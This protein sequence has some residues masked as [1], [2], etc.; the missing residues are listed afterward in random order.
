MAWWDDLWLNEAFATWMAFDIVHKWRPE[1][2]MW[3]DFG[4]SRDS[5]LEL[6]ALENTHPIYTKVRT[7]AEATENF[8]L[9]TYEKGASVI[10]MLERYLGEARFQR[11]VR[12]Y[13]KRHREQNAV[14]ADLW[15]ALERHAGQEV[16]T[17][18]RPWVER[19][20][21]PLLRVKRTG[22]GRRTLLLE[23]EP[24]SARGPG[25][26]RS[27]PP[28][29]LPIVLKIGAGRERLER[30]LLRKPRARLTLPRGTRF[31]YANADEGGF[32][33]PLHDAE[34]LRELGKHVR[35]LS[36]TERLGLVTHGWALVA[37]G[38]AELPTFLD[39]LRP[40]AKERDPDVLAALQAPLWHV[41]DRIAGE[42][43]RAALRALVAET[44][45]PALAKLSWR[46]A[47]REPDSERLRRAELL[48][49]VCLLA[50]DPEVTAEA[51]RQT[52][53]YL[54]DPAA[55]DPN[56]VGAVVVASA[57]RGDT[58]LHARY[59]ALSLKA[60]TPQE[61][62]RFRM[63]LGEFRD[64][65]CVDRSLALCLGDRIPKQDL[66][67]LLAR[68]LENPAARERTWAFMR[69]NWP[70]LGRRVS[71][72]LVSRLI[73]A[74]PA[75]QG[76]RKRREVMAFFKRH[77]V[78][79]A[80]RALQQADERFRLEAVLRERAAPA[81]ARWLSQGGRG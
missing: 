43:E 78:P 24:F 12:D 62:R 32:Y 19:P 57:R 27:Q 20:G 34:S 38:Y 2:R 4:H 46:A 50:E 21:F 73:E 45:R 54:K 7:P 56:L 23:Q 28:W 63:A 47:R 15:R 75:L 40:L 79:T 64:D 6:D 59:L 39:L 36:A 8:D 3:N 22:Q 10:R 74:T 55:L 5:A 58:A 11:G 51:V 42:A 49:L 1:L 52:R 17:V 30:V 67:L 76:E 53:A 69:R 68:M 60:K 16:D 71:P 77:P 48:S 41:L 72:Q 66:P 44:F 14:A 31:V 61:R 33:R 13:I 25:A 65:T 81:L 9:I 70:K 80:Q 37:A 18:V 29:P 35:E 26:A